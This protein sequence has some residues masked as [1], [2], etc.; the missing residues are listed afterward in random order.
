MGVFHVFVGVMYYAVMKMKG[1][2]N[3]VNFDSFIFQRIPEYC[4]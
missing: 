4:E 1:E 3:K 2:I